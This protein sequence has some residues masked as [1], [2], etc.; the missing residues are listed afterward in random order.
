TRSQAIDTMLAFH[1]AGLLLDESHQEP[2]LSVLR[3][4]D[5]RSLS[6]S[7]AR[8]L[9]TLLHDSDRQR[10]CI[11]LESE[12]P[13]RRFAAAEALAEYPEFVDAILAAAAHDAALF[14]AAVRSTTLWRPSVSGLMAVS[15][16]PAPSLQEH[17]AGL[18]RI[19]AALPMVD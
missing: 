7:G 16:L 19:A 10:L 17:R 15:E 18:L 13:Q 6:A 9:S 14:G 4:I 5:P 11:V 12:T 1:R 3:D 8:L 2:V